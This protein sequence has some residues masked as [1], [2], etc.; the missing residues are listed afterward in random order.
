[1]ISLVVKNWIYRLRPIFRCAV[2]TS[3]SSNW[4]LIV[5]ESDLTV[6]TVWGAS[7]S[8]GYGQ[9]ADQQLVRRS[10][11]LLALHVRVPGQD[12][13]LCPPPSLHGHPATRLPHLLS[14]LRHH[15]VH[16]HPCRLRERRQRK[17]WTQSSSSL[18]PSAPP[19][20]GKAK[21]AVVHHWRHSARG[22]GEKG[23]GQRAAL[24]LPALHP[25]PHPSP[26]ADV[27]RSL[28]VGAATSKTSGIGGSSLLWRGQP[29]DTHCNGVRQIRAKRWTSQFRSGRLSSFSLSSLFQ[30]SPPFS[31]FFVYLLIY[32]VISLLISLFISW[33]I[34]LIAR[35]DITVMVDWA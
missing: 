16:N 14:K 32:S 35:P 3:L 22:G 28:P 18:P 26:A 33:L 34:I 15:R 21:E 29:G 13:R 11:P 27:T 2:F 24:S 4:L 9:H 23:G 6:R 20:S 19:W 5:N 7:A 8:R 10:L 25:L 30:C 1:M 31:R 17:Q 12:T